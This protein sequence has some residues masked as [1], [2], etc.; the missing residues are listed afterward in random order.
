MMSTTRY[1][2]VLQVRIQVAQATRQCHKRERKEQGQN[3][4]ISCLIKKGVCNPPQ[5]LVSGTAIATWTACKFPYFQSWLSA[6][7]THSGKRWGLLPSLL[8]QLSV[9][10]FTITSQFKKTKQ[11]KTTSNYYASVSTC[12]YGVLILTTSRIQTIHLLGI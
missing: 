8:L 4:M 11:T 12:I 1:S 3:P 10:L 9:D 6:L 5:K 2:V 7:I